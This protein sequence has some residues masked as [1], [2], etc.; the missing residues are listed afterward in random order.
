[1]ATTQDNRLMKIATPLQD[2]FLLINTLSAYEEISQLFSF[3]LE[4]LHEENEPGIEPT[5]V[6]ADKMLGQA[7]TI[8]VKQ[9]DGTE[10]F[11]SGIVNKFSQGNRNTRFSF[12]YATV[13][14]HVWILTQKYQSRIFQHKSVP[15]ILKEVL[16][17]FEVS[18]ELQGTFKPRNYCVQYNESDF[19]FASRL[20]EEEGIYY[21]FEHND[22][23]HKL[24][25]ANTPQSHPDCPSK[26]EIPYFIKVSND[27]DFKT[28]VGEWQTAHNLQTG[29][30]TFWD[31]NFQAPTNKLDAIQ[32]SLFNISDNQKLEKYEFP[33]G[34]GRKYDDID[35]SGGVRS[36]VQ[37]IF[38]EKQ[39]I[40][41]IA[42][43][44]LDARYKVTNGFADC[45]SMTAGYKFNFTQHIAAGEYLITSVKHMVEQNPSYVSD[46]EIE[47]PYSNTFTCIAHGK[48]SPPF[49]PLR[50][51][52][53]P[54]IQGSQTAVVVGPAGEEIFTD[55][56]GRIKVQ[57]HWDREGQVDSN[58]SCWIRVAQ[59]WAGNKWGMVFIP[60]IGMEVIVH[61]IEGNPDQPIITGCVYNPQTMPPY[62]LP[63]EKTK[64]T[65]KSD[66]SKGGKGFNEFRIE[67][68]KG[69]EQVFL[70]GE[71][72]LD[73]RI[74]NDAMEFI[75]RDRH[76]IVEQHQLEKVTKDKQ[77]KVGGDKNEKVDGSVSLNV[78]SD[79]DAKAGQKY[80]LNAGREVHIKSG[81][82]LVLESGTTLTL[83]VGGNFIN[84]N[85]GG[86]F[87][88]GTMVMLNSGGAAG[89][90][91]GANPD[92]PKPPKE[93][94]QADPGMRTK[95]PKPKAPPAKPE[96]SSPAAKVLIN[97]AKN[98][99]AF[100]EICSRK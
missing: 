44:S 91:S 57:F 11:F 77:L 90:G 31:Y 54:I 71:K 37:N 20:M 92:A 83:K 41:E 6:E 22:S 47:E 82:N 3:E 88:K 30:F 72:N 15:D 1:M 51:T 50:Q 32:P 85:S 21:F 95:L 74:K 84:I 9:R 49:R 17:G 73:V 55:K 63:D 81:M 34:Y 59:S 29:K 65:L 89:S 38:N 58:S 79:I 69:K 96:F 64:S 16:D 87:I 75:K 28:S 26:S 53:K 27:E 56:F 93:A 86:I 61:F 8:R 36:D 97:A 66:S 10:R 18:Y 60:R 100:C 68:E 19:D 33:A 13:V 25:I 4:L 2:D 43:Q 23:K 24:I 48:G 76:L 52:P 12:Y 80:A 94:D 39:T 62:T 7:V 5:V 14:P 40:T 98:G 42:M 35:S 67:D 99:T 70:H 45:A 46:D 78:G